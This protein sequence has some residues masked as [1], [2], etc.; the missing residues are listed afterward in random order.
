MYRVIKA[1]GLYGRNDTNVPTI[2]PPYPTQQQQYNMYPRKGL[3]AGGNTPPAKHKSPLFHV[4]STTPFRK[5]I[6]EKDGVNFITFTC[7]NWLP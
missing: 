5:A 1:A 7:H 2:R 3:S 6:A 4:T